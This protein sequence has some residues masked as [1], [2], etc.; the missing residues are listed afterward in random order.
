MNIFESKAKFDHGLNTVRSTFDQLEVWCREVK[1]GNGILWEVLLEKIRELLEQNKYSLAI[2]G[3]N[4]LLIIPKNEDLMEKVQV[5]ISNIL[6][7]MFSMNISD[8]DEMDRLLIETTRWM[9]MAA[10]TNLRDSVHEYLHANHVKLNQFIADTNSPDLILAY[11]HTLLS[12]DFYNPMRVMMEYLLGVEWPFLDSKIQEEQFADFLWIAFYL[13]MDDVLIEISKESGR[14][15]EQVQSPEILL[16]K[17]YY[18]VKNNREHHSQRSEN[19]VALMDQ[20]RLFEESE[21][22]C[23]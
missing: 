18:D 14:F 23:S 15:I 9:K 3:L 19:I 16:Y 7:W 12:F 5:S 1:T 17:K 22:P 13:S 11:L 6:D 20:S 10:R 2:V 8:L 21:K 4:H